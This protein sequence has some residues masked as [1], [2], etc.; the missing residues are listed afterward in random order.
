MR[1]T[2]TLVSLAQ[3]R[4]WLMTLFYGHLFV[5]PIKLLFPLTHISLVRIQISYHARPLPIH[6]VPIPVAEDV[7]S[8]R[9]YHLKANLSGRPA[10]FG[11]WV[12]LELTEKE[13][14]DPKW[15][16]AMDSIKQIY[17][18]HIASLLRLWLNFYLM[19]HIHVKDERWCH[20]SGWWK[21][22]T[23]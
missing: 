17:S 18:V 16:S 7:P 2:L 5:E 23:K 15:R 6:F 14:V 19:P 3:Y 21:P 4:L 22:S 8:R 11:N 12:V 13:R 9:V 20:F 10:G 1:G